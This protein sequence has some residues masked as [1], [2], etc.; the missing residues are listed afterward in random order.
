[1]TTAI[2]YLFQINHPTP[3][4]LA[5][6]AVTLVN[7][8]MMLW[9][10][11]RYGYTNFGSYMFMAAC[12]S[13]LRAS[14]IWVTPFDLAL[15]MTA[16]AFTFSLVPR[17]SHRV[18]AVGIGVALAGVLA[19]D[20][21][22]DWPGYSAA[23]YHARIYAAVLLLGVSAACVAESWVR[24]KDLDWRAV[25]AVAWFLTL[26]LT[27]VQWRT[28]AGTAGYWRQYWH[29]ALAGKIAAGCCLGGWILTCTGK[30]SKIV[31]P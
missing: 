6:V 12:S 9:L 23:A 13:L 31:L 22:A 3:E 30:H 1:M 5:W 29:I 28:D 20:G 14:P 27:L 11:V 18:F 7:A 15:A 16:I 17:G 25:I 24:G 2:A 10:M 26:F 21:L 8:G 19:M 4:K